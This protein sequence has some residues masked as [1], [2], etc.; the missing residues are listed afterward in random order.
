MS[1][2]GQYPDPRHLW[3][4]DYG[5]GP[6]INA[7]LI[8]APSPSTSDA[9]GASSRAGDRGR[10]RQYGRRRSGQGPRLHVIHEARPAA[11]LSD[12]DY[13]V[14]C[15]REPSPASTT[16]TSPRFCEKRSRPIALLAVQRLRREW[17][18][19]W[20]T[21]PGPRSSGGSPGSRS[22]QIGTV[23][24]T[25]RRRIGAEDA[26]GTGE[27]GRAADRAR[28]TMRIW[29]SGNRQTSGGGQVFVDQPGEGRDRR[30][31]SP[32]PRGE[33]GESVSWR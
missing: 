22:L 11:E 13:Q 18:G 30:R 2:P 6:Q 14:G 33:C 28:S 26:A 21:L 15:R 4:A 20:P 1:L 23:A 25:S 5:S 17:G 12:F 27:L 29:F 9:A 31:G 32:P 3:V 16:S 19:D 10:P 24:Q 8:S 7:T